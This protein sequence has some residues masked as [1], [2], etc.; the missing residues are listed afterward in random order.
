MWSTHVSCWSTIDISL[1]AVQA[2]STHVSCWILLCTV[3]HLS[4]IFGDRAAK[5]V[6]A[7]QDAQVVAPTAFMHRGDISANAQV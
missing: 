7:F 2:G 3:H 5:S 4:D 1:A 6:S